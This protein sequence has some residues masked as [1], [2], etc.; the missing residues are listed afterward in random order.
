MVARDTTEHIGLLNLILIFLVIVLACLC[1]LLAIFLYKTNKRKLRKLLAAIN[2]NTLFLST[3]GQ[4]KHIQVGVMPAG[5]EVRKVEEREQQQE[6]NNIIED[7]N[8]E[9][10]LNLLKKKYFSLLFI[11]SLFVSACTRVCLVC[12][13]VLQ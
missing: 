1:I 3:P 12:P 8:K 11:I 2:T 10:K 6:F 4:T 5:Q 9:F 13:C 7:T